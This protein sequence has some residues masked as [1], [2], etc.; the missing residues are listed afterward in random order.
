MTDTGSV[1]DH[2]THGSLLD[3]IQ[4]RL[5]AMGKSTSTVKLDDLAPIDEFHI[6]GRQASIDFLG[7]LNLDPATHALD[8][9]CGLGGASRFT[10]S[11]YGA[12]V[13]GIDLTGEYVETGQ[14]LCGWLGLGD[15]INLHQGSALEM[16]FADGSFDAA[17]MMHVGMNIADK[18][19]LF[20]EVARVLKDGGVFGVYDVMLTGDDDLIFPLPWSQ[21]P[22]NSAV[23]SPDAYRG[24]LE[25]AGLTVSN[26]RNR[27]DFALEFFAEVKAKSKGGPPPL[28]THILMG[29]SAPQK[30]TNMIENISAGRIAPVEMIARKAVG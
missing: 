2:Y 11:T 14:A 27:R 1:A 22:A 5:Q 3:T 20:A 24:A 12:Q 8:V 13:S 28:G 30:I 19:L 10:A 15:K 4:S 18:T 29:S 7:Q 9:G 21:S 26:E 17:Y 16:P 25:A 6:G 23:A